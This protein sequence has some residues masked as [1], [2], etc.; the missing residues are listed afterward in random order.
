[1]RRL[2]TDLFEVYDE[3][4]RFPTQALAG[5]TDARLLFAIEAL[6]AHVGFRLVFFRSA[7]SQLALLDDLVQVRA[8]TTPI[9]TLHLQREAILQPEA[10][11]LFGWVFLPRKE[12]VA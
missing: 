5:I 8:N 1:M 12:G 7:G 3:L 9:R 2:P 11:S 10:G 4:V 6:A